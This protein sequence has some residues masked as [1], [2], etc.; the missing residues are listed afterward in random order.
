MHPCIPWVFPNIRQRGGGGVGRR[1]LCRVGRFSLLKFNML[2][3]IRLGWTSLKLCF[4]YLI[5]VVVI[6]FLI[7]S[8]LRHLKKIKEKIAQNIIKF[9]D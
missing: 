2:H 4:S 5:F 9:F 6:V 8:Y 1:A 3:V 7:G